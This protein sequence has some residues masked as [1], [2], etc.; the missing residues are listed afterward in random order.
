MVVVKELDNKKGFWSLYE[1]AEAFNLMKE[2]EEVKQEFNDENEFDED[3]KVF[4]QEDDDMLKIM[5]EKSERTFWFESYHDTNEEYW[6]VMEF[7]NGTLK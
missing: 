7:E 3:S 4:L 2:F 5:L 1:I 6:R